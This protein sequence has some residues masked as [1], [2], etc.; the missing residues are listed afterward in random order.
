[1]LPTASFGWILASTC[2]ETL[3][4]TAVQ[5]QQ[6][7]VRLPAADR[8][9]TEHGITPQTQEELPTSAHLLER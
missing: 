1:M 6:N 2:C 4:R 9:K 8:K 5:A 3:K 7:R